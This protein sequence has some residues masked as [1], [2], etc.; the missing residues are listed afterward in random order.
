MTK[1]QP[2]AFNPGGKEITMTYPE[3]TQQLDF[4]S[5]NQSLEEYRDEAE[6]ITRHPDAIF[7]MAHGGFRAVRELSGYTIKA[8]AFRYGI[9]IRT[10]ENWSMG[11]RECPEY[12]WRLI[13]YAV[14]LE[15]SGKV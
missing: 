5:R 10:V 12:V 14:F 7:T 3:F 6:N 15:I 11:A 4:A 9:P 2:G 8:F 1:G 13:A